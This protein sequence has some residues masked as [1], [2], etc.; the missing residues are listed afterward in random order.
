MMKIKKKII[1]FALAIAAVAFMGIVDNADAI[2][3]NITLGTPEIPGDINALENGPI[4]APAIP[5]QQY[6]LDRYNRRA[7]KATVMASKME[8]ANRPPEMVTAMDNMMSA[9]VKAAIKPSLK[10][11]LQQDIARDIQTRILP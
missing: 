11:Q 1:R 6:A 9:T 4:A 3:I 2:Q 7:E 10:A 8:V 5:L